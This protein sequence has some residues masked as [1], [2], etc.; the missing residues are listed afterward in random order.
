[1]VAP[2][3]I[4]RALAVTALCV[5]L[6]PWLG[7]D[8]ARADTVSAADMQALTNQLRFAA[9]A[10]T[11]PADP[12]VASAAQHHADYNSLNGTVGHYETAG[13]TGYTGYGPRDRVAAAGLVTSFV[14]EVATGGGSG[15]LAGVQQLW[16]APYHRL[17]LMH[18]NA[19]TLGWGYSSLGGRE[20][21]VADIVYD[22]GFRAVEFARSPYDGQANVPT[23][24]SGNESPNPLPSGASRPV[25]YPIMVVYSGAQPVDMRAAEIVAPD[26]SRAPLYYAP[27]QFERDYQVIVP[28]QPL[29]SGTRYHVRFDITVNG[30][31][32]TNEW[33]FTTA[34]SGGFTAAP[35]LTYHEAFVDQSPYPTLQP[36][37]TQSLTVQLRN[38]G[39]A[40]W[41][42]GVPGQQANL[43]IN[44]DATIFAAAGMAVNWLAPNR[45]A[46]QTEASVPPNGTAAFT[47]TVRAPAA[48]GGYR[49]PLRGVIDGTAWLDDLGVFLVVTSD[50]GYHS[51]W[52]AQSPYPTLAPGA[53][54]GPLWVSFTNSGTRPWVRG[55]LGQQADLGINGDDRTW[56]SLA[57]LWLTPDRPAAQAEAT[58]AP[59]SLGTFSFQVRAPTLPGTYLIH[60]RPVVDGTSWLE[61]DGVYLV[62]TVT[63]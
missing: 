19:T 23:S 48:P 31:Y 60:L 55:I 45:V 52:A 54:S 37:M 7:P 24:W 34:G 49:L 33:D 20:S 2:S 1:M 18:P 17:G 36:G 40:T 21:I 42:R 14:S 47:F 26:G 41:R 13:L 32:A 35:A 57:V 50:W 43:A 51:H 56:S 58:V 4:P 3:A 44:G 61:D 22:F 30:A 6:L 10:P 46:A 11:V 62:V 5:A 8:A 28:Q 12:R 16:D 29:A 53:L 9:G 63:N 59:G 15:P 39:T 38:T 25:G 27:Q